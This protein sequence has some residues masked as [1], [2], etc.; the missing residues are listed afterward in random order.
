MV[1]KFQYCYTLT[2]MTSDFQQCGI[3]TS[4][5]PEEPCNLFLSLVITNVFSQ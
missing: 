1:K 4:V 3:F 5:D 2:A